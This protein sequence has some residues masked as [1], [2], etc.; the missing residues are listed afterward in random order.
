MF[1]FCAEC[2]NERKSDLCLINDDFNDFE[3]IIKVK[4]TDRD[5]LLSYHWKVM[6]YLRKLFYA[7]KNILLFSLSRLHLLNT[8]ISTPYH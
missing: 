1:C 8:T 3:D 7:K 6:T 4:I 5:F 2:E